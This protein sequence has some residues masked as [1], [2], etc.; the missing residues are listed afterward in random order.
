VVALSDHAIGA[1]CAMGSS[2]TWA[3]INLFVRRLAPDFGSVAVNALRSAAGAVFIVV[4]VAAAGGFADLGGMSARAFWLLAGSVILA[5]GLGDTVFFESVRWLGLGR[6]MT[7]SMVYP[8]MSAVLAVALLGEPLSPRVTTGAIITLL[9]IVL[10][11][12]PRGAEP[13]DRRHVRLGLAAALLAALA[14]ATSVI[15]LKPALEEVDAVSAQAV[16]LPLAAALLWCTPWAWRI[17]PQ[18]RARGRAAV[19]QLVL[20]GGLTAASSILFVAGVGRA[21]VAIGTVLSSTSPIFALL[22]A[23][24]FLGERVRPAAVAGTAL[25]VLGIVVLR[26]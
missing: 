16:R 14:W 10:T 1:L 19:W 13:A 5:V 17:G 3:L 22:L 26:S 9:G 21:G 11:V 7:V 4:W 18:L 15:L 25:T 23:V 12:G 20:L 6:A 2:L 8:L 24:F